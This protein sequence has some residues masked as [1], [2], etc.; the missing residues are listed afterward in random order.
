MTCYLELKLQQYNRS[1]IGKTPRFLNILPSLFF[2]SRQKLQTIHI[3]SFFSESVVTVGF[4]FPP[5][6]EIL[7]FCLWFSLSEI[8]Y[9][10]KQL[11]YTV[12][13]PGRQYP[14]KARNVLLSAVQMRLRKKNYRYNLFK[15]YK[16]FLINI[17]LAQNVM[18]LV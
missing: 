13:V 17:H 3:Y 18:A 14:T 16:I 4:S 8:L 15:W 2:S 11:N 5:S 6:D 7:L 12:M 10:P 1:G 9:G